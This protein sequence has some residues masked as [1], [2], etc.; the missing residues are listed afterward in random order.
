MSV[1]DISTADIARED[2]S[3][4]NGNLSLDLITI[5]SIFSK[6][7][8]RIIDCFI[9]IHSAHSMEVLSKSSCNSTVISFDL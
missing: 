4:I 5:F 2:Y 3:G 8:F 9:S 7:F 6:Y 1:S